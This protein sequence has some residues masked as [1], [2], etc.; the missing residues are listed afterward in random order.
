MELSHMVVTPL[1]I[2]MEPPNYWVVEESSLPRVNSQV[3]CLFVGE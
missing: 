2:N 1:Q 3:L